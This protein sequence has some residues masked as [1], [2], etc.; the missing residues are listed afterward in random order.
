[1]TGGPAAEGH[2]SPGLGTPGDGPPEFLPPRPSTVSAPVSVPTPPS[3]R[4]PQ[5]PRPRRRAVVAAVLA[6]GLLLIGLLSALPLLPPATPTPTLGQ[7]APPEV[8]TAS[9]PPAAG[10]APV[11]VSGGDVGRPVAFTSAT[12]SG[13]FTVSSATWADSG[14]VAPDA[15]LRYLVL[16]VTVACTRGEVPVEEFLLLASTGQEGHLPS[17]GPGLQ[18]PLQGRQLTSGQRVSGQ[19]GYA[20]APGAVEVFLLDESLQRLA[21]IQIPAP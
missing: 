17:F 9:P 20:L 13:T 1:M 5:R 8:V 14:E 10:A 16:D 2:G 4:P 3:G 19:V 11:T 15:G 7:S 21:G 6:G 12:G 18:H